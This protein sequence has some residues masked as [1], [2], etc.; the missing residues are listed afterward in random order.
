MECTYGDRDHRCSHD[1]VEKNLERIVKRAAE[2]KGH[3]LVPAFAIGRT[4]TLLYHLN[5]LIEARRIPNIPVAVDTPFG[6]RVTETYAES[7]RLFDAVALDKI[8]RGDDPLDFEGLYAV[9]KGRDSV[10]LRDV[11][12]PLLII[13]GSGMCTGGASWVTCRSSCR[14]NRPPSFSW[15]FKP[16]ARAGGRSKKQRRIAPPDAA[17]WLSASTVKR[18]SCVRASRPSAGCRHM[19]IAVS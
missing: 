2:K 5:T 16:P 13:A 10:R 15:D 14:S 17:P 1:D 4:Q 7:R 3:I 19:P 18:H 6:L 11:P 9:W 12:G 8:S